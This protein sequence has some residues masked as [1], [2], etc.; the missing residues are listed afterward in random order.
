MQASGFSSSW[1][2]KPSCLARDK[3]IGTIY[4]YTHSRVYLSSVKRHLGNVSEKN[5]AEIPVEKSGPITTYQ[6]SQARDF[7]WSYL[8]LESIWTCIT[9][10]S[11]QAKLESL[12]DYRFQL[13][14]PL[15]NKLFNLTIR[16]AMNVG[17]S[18]QYPLPISS[19]SYN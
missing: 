12:K 15:L 14:L 4:A 2:G 7:Y 8:N 11:L 1:G 18:N 13:S 17:V 9:A 10:N 5:K 19:T 16:Q 3:D 6:F